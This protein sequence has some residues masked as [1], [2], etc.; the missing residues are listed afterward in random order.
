MIMFTR[1]SLLLSMAPMLIDLIR[2]I[3]LLIPGN[4]KGEQKL[5]AVRRVLE[6]VFNDDGYLS[7]V[8]PQL[9]VAISGI[10]AMLNDEGLLSKNSSGALAESELPFHLQPASE[11][12]RTPARADGLIQR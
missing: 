2:A 9:E 6:S 12:N 1:I 11:Q 5:K 3:E 4:G 7:E 10:V 8:W